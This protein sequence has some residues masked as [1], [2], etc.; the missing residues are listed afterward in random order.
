[1]AARRPLPL[2]L[3]FQAFIVIALVTQALQWPGVLAARTVPG[4]YASTKGVD[5]LEALLSLRRGSAS[6]QLQGEGWTNPCGGFESSNKPGDSALLS[7]HEPCFG[8]G[9]ELRFCW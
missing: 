5:D 8:P 9:G 3:A 6:S 4:E 7:V 1:M 2:L